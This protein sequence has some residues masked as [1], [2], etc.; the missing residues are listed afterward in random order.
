M[1]TYIGSERVIVRAV[2]S[3]GNEYVLRPK[4]NLNS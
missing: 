4:N 3:N 1:P 2:D